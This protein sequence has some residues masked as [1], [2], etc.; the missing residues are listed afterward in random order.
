MI[1]SRDNE[2][3]DDLVRWLTCGRLPEAN[4]ELLSP[5]FHDADFRKQRDVSTLQGGGGLLPSNFRI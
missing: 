5:F 2:G 4:K 3:Q 1:F